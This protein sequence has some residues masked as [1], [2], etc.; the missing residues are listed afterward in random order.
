MKAMLLRQCGR[1]EDRPLRMAEVERPQPGPGE[2]LVR[3]AVC[4]LCHTDLHTVEG[5]LALP[6]LPIIPGHQVV[7]IV[8]ALGAGAGGFNVGDRVGVAWLHATC[9]RCALCL[10][11][12]ENLCREAR[13]TGF[14]AHGG[15][16]E[17]LV[18]PADFAYRI[19]G[20]FAP[21]EAA[22]LLCAGIIGYRALRLSAIEPGQ[23]LGL[24]G[25]GAS[26]HLAIQIAVHWRC[27][28][29]V[30]TRS[31]EHQHL[32]R[33]LG[34]EWAGE[35]AQALPERLDGAILF[36]PA[37]DL[38]PPALAALDRGGSLALA[39]I[40]LSPIPTL[41]Y[42]RHLYYERSVRSVTA[43]TRQDG[44]DLLALAAAIPLR[45]QTQAFDL[46]EANEAL[47]ALKTSRLRAAGVLRVAPI[48]PA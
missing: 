36:A 22:P 37:G 26:A 40:Y 23:R 8:E 21:E 47:L 31:A 33:S 19:P 35:R 18:V 30:V 41:D 20:G 27:R 43:N 11:G 13:F 34:A 29:F 9:G 17:Y 10:A 45:P 2:V 28:V 16:A 42:D 24:F 39:G 12:K 46:A 44:R 6:R 5:E 48:R 3:V 38:V 25:F 15:F 7:G 32:A 4:G 14:H 1:V